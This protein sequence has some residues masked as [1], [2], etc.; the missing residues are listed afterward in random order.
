MMRFVTL[1]SFVVSLVLLGSV[2]QAQTEEPPPGYLFITGWYKDAGLQREYGQVAGP[3]IREY[4]LEAGVLG[5]T[6]INLRVL[7]GDWIPGRIMLVKFPSEAHVKRFWWSDAYQEAIKIRA[8]A[9]ALDIAQVDGVPGV[10][11]L[12]DG[13]AAYLVFLAKIEDRKTFLEDYA[14]FSPGILK[15]HGG[16]FIVS[17]VRSNT[18]VLEGSFPNASIL[19]IEFPSKQALTDFWTDPEYKRLSE[20]RKSTGKWS[21]AEITPQPQNPN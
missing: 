19:V 16:Q 7:E 2:T 10:T 11:P 18:E 8:A 13:K 5:L 14:P 17:S 20:I 3:I 1:A 9:S 21:V 6:G 4:G 12:L 15:K